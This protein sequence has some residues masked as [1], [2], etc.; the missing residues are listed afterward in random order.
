MKYILLFFLRVVLHTNASTYTGGTPLQVPRK[1]QGTVDPLFGASSWRISAQD[2]PGT[3]KQAACDQFTRTFQKTHKNITQDFFG[4][5]TTL[6]IQDRRRKPT[7]PL[8]KTFFG[9]SSS[10]FITATHK[11]S[12]LLFSRLEMFLH[13]TGKPQ[14]LH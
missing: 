5:K 9:G 3:T 6:K 13:R 4:G 10:K 8:Y 1:V 11:P 7:K 14:N 2:S 12:Y